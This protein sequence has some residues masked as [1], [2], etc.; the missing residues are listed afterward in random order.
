MAR[1]IPRQNVFNASR[2]DQSAVANIAVVA[3][4]PVATNMVNTV[5]IGIG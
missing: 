4:V 5:L 2:N 3:A 1:A